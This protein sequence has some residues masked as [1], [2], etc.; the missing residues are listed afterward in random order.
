MERFASVQGVQ[1]RGAAQYRRRRAAVLLRGKLSEAPVHGRAPPRKGGAGAAARVSAGATFSRDRQYRYRLWRYWDLSRAPLLM[2]M[3]NPSTADEERNDPTVER[4]ERRA[5]ASGF[6]GL[7][8]AN[9]FALRSTDPKAL[10]AHPSPVG[11]RNDAAILAMAGEA[12]QVVCAWGVHGALSD[13]GQR[14]ASR[15]GREG[16]RLG[17]LGLTREGHPRHPLY[18]ASA[19]AIAPWEGYV[20]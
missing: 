14:V 3:L 15:L 6:G 5:R 17:V 20:R 9:I 8:V 1:H 16:I 11:P 10:Y 13:R 12:G 19:T 7:L 18:M 4:C 2:I